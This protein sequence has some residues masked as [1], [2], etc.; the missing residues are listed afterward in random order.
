MLAGLALER[1]RDVELTLVVDKARIVG[2]D[3]RKAAVNLKLDANGLDLQRLSVDGF[4]NTTIEASGH[5][6][7]Q[8]PSPR[9]NIKVDLDARDLDGV[10]ALADKFAPSAVDPIRRLAGRQPTAK[11]HTNLG[12]ESSGPSLGHQALDRQDRR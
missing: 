12:V 9:G 8:S 5:I 2:M 3:T 7:T 4:G 1:P 10:I 6:E 11:L